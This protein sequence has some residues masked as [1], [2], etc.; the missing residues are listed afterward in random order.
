MEVLD[1]DAG[2]FKKLWL[3]ARRA[4]DGPANAPPAVVEPRHAADGSLD[5]HQG[6]VGAVAFSPDGLLLASA[7]HDATVRLWNAYTG[8]PVGE[9]LR[10]HTGDVAAVAFSPDG[11]RL[12]TASHDGTVRLWTM[13]IADDPAAELTLCERQIAALMAEGLSNRAIAERIRIS[14][15]TLE[16]RIATI[17]V[18]FGLPPDAEHHRRVLAVRRFLRS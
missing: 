15:R 4:G 1:G 16:T 3:A 10:G 18:K 14:D 2:E 13:N 17:F 11:R 12:A 7:G 6:I 8:G 5:G 9:P